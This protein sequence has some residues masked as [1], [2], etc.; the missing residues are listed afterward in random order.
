[1]PQEGVRDFMNNF[2]ELILQN[3][4]L[5]PQ[6]LC[7]NDILLRA[8]DIF[9]R[10]TY[11]G[12]TLM[13]PCY[14]RL[15]WLSPS[16][17]HLPG[18]VHV[19]VSAHLTCCHGKGEVFSRVLYFR[20]EKFSRCLTYRRASPRIETFLRDIQAF[21]VQIWRLYV[22]FNFFGWRRHYVN[23]YNPRH[24]DRLRESPAL[25]PFS[26]RLLNWRPLLLIRLIFLRLISYSTDFRLFHGCIHW[27]LFLQRLFFDLRD[28][29]FLFDWG[30]FIALIDLFETLIE[31]VHH[32]ATVVLEVHGGHTDG[33]GCELLRALNQGGRLID[34][35]V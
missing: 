32:Q 2:V 4:S 5:L 25:D 19:R 33:T 16:S 22:C 17:G 30:L 9:K 20:D 35:V 24:H 34:D 26:L 8:W 27:L 18:L 7:V 29:W 15:N 1:M 14:D 28:G 23:L 12:S 3:F 13:D 6:S 31:V 11:V 10:I 21:Q